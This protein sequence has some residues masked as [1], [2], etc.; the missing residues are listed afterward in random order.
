MPTAPEEQLL[1][2]TRYPEP[3]STKTRMI[4]LLGRKGAADLQQFTMRLVQDMLQLGEEHVEIRKLLAKHREPLQQL[5]VGLPEEQPTGS[6]PAP[7]GSPV[8]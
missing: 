3:G 6:A 2:F 1:I 5:G 4:P 7:F 8:P